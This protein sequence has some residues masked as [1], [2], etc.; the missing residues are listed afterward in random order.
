MKFIERIAMQTSKIK[1]PRVMQ[2]TSQRGATLV[3]ALI[4]IVILAIG[5]LGMAGMTAASIQ[6]NQTSRMR[7]TGVLLVNDLAERARI[8]AAGFDGGGYDRTVQYNFGANVA[9]PAGC[10]V[11]HVCDAAGIAAYDQAQ[12]LQNVNNRL[13]GGGAVVTTDTNAGIRSMNVWLIW[14]EP[15]DLESNLTQNC[16]AA[17]GNANGTRCMYFRVTL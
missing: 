3:E 1:Q 4:A 6:H 7:G 9:A 8:N 5:L 16:P 13:P 12:W 14:T 17:A 15:S 2:R 10:T 11:G